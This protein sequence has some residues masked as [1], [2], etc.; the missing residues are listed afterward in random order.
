MVD[1]T[2]K[3]L[4]DSCK[5]NLPPM[6]LGVSCLAIVDENKHQ[7]RCLIIIKSQCVRRQLGM[8]VENKQML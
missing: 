7:L 1:G 3:P 2:P 8:E 6:G 4:G 5:L